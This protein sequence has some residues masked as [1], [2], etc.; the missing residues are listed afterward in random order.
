MIYSHTDVPG[1]VKNASCKRNHTSGA[2]LITNWD[3]L[4]SLDLTNADPGIVY[5]VQWRNVTCGQNVSMG[6]E[7]V[8]GTNT[9]Y[10]IHHPHEIYEVTITPRNN[11]MAA[12]DG[13]RRVMR[14]SQLYLC[15]CNTFNCTF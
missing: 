14:G 11:I 3:P 15:T 13:E 10:A 2:Y 1:R 12:R 4:P 9:S 7:T 5:R 6:E 8:N